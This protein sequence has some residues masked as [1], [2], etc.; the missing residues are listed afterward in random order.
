MFIFCHKKKLYICFSNWWYTENQSIFFMLQVN[1]RS[2]GNLV[3]EKGL[4]L[5]R[6]E[7]SHS[8]KNKEFGEKKIVQE[9]QC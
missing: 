7:E 6:K 8:W 4:S 1:I 9:I 2:Q 5:V 3:I